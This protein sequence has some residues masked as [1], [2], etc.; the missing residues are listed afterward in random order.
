MTPAPRTSFGASES[1]R[2]HTPP[3]LTGRIKDLLAGKKIAMTG[4]TGFIGEQLLWTFLTE[5]PDSRTAVL[6]RRKGS[7]SAEDR[8]RSLLKKPIFKQVVAEAGTVEDLMAA[9]VEVIEGD[10]PE[11]P[12]LPRDIDVLIHF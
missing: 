3:L 5:C 8:V 9:R 2:L 6:V 1:T 10:L 7:L 11:V 4:V 12:V